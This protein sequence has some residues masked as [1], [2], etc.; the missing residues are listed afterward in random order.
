MSECARGS[1]AG[2]L[3]DML[4][5]LFSVGGRQLAVP[6]NNFFISL[7]IRPDALIEWC[8][9]RH[10]LGPRRVPTF[11]RTLQE[12]PRL[13]PLADRFCMHAPCRALREIVF[14]RLVSE[15]IDRASDTSRR[16]FVA[17][18]NK[19]DK[20][21]GEAT[22]VTQPKSLLYFSNIRCEEMIA[23]YIRDPT[24]EITSMSM[25]V[26]GRGWAVC[27]FGNELFQRLGRSANCFAVFRENESLLHN[28]SNVQVLGLVTDVWR[29]SFKQFKLNQVSLRL[30]NSR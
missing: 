5:H 18:L 9:R 10:S 27:Q 22:N 28:Q 24:G 2:G 17:L 21:T 8:A 13:T 7:C 30:F 19:F 4:A 1:R 14:Q 11:N 16:N 12:C 29:Q 26:Y 3:N 23:E 15:R 20:R 25:L 6:I